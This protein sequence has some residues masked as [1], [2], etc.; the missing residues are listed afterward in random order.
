MVVR[1]GGQR[2]QII[3]SLVSIAT[4]GWVIWAFQTAPADAPLYDGSSDWLWIIAT[5]ITLIASLLLAGSFIGNPALPGPP[6][7]ARMMTVRD[8]VGAMRVTR[9][10]MMWGI[11]LWGVS[12]MLIAPR[13][14]VLILAGSMVFLAIGGSLGQDAK[15]RLLMGADWKAW[16]NKTSFVPQL[17]KLFSLHWAVWLGGVVFWF[18][19][20]TAH[21]IFGIGGAGL[22]RWL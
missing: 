2:F 16:E 19:A 7:A 9:H 13:P 4:L 22:W 21:D 8:P 18:S 20:Q 12:H 15:K 1:F 10:P 5:V 17:G 3:Y 6:N 11:A 14:A